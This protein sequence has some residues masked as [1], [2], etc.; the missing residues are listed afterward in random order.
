MP[1]YQK[2]HPGGPGRPKGSRNRL[3]QRLDEIAEEHSPDIL[4]NVASKAK[5]GEAWASKLM[6]DMPWRRAGTSPTPIDLPDV[7]TAENLAVA[8]ARLIA[9]AAAGDVSI[10]EAAAFASLLEA[11]RR[12]VHTRDQERRLEEIEKAI[13][14]RDAK[15]GAS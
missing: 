4:Q 1:R 7:T 11:H 14:V 13:G 10:P 3:T 6:L 8:Q 5:E 9:A 12:A 2:G 15:N